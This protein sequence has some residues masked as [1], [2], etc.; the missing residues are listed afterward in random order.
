M[1]IILTGLALF[2]ADRQINSDINRQI[3][4]DVKDR[5]M[6]IQLDRL[7]MTGLA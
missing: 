4:R 7:C 3:D 5:Y 2:F 1:A 6:G